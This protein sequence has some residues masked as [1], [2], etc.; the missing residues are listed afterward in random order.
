MMKVIL[1]LDLADD[2]TKQKAL[3]KVSGLFGLES[4]SLDSKDKKLTV[5]G[6]IDPIDV[7]AKLR[8]ICYTEIISVG[9]AKEPEKKKEEPK[10]EDPKKAAEDKKKAEEAA[11]QLLKAQQAYYQN[12]YYYHN[13]PPAAVAP[14]PAYPAY[15][16]R[17]SEEDPNACVIS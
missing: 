3:K 13:H 7:V 1:K 5:T 15:Y 6:D 11:A 14:A 12:L 2:K 16:Q 17:S 8:K 9:P 10:K 4:I